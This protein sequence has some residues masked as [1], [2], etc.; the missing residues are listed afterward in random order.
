MHLNHKIYLFK[1]EPHMATFAKGQEGFIMVL[2][3]AFEYELT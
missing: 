1:T 3:Q 2:H